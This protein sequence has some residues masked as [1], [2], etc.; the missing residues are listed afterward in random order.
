VLGDSENT[1]YEQLRE[2][3]GAGFALERQR[4]DQEWALVTREEL[5]RTQVSRENAAGRAVVC[6][7]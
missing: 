7:R 4:L 1:V 5:W 2:I 3:L 6:R